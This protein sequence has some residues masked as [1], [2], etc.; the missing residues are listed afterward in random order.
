MEIYQSQYSRINVVCMII[1]NG[2]MGYI[3][4][5]TLEEDPVNLHTQA[6]IFCGVILNGLIGNVLFLKPLYLMFYILRE[7]F[8]HGRGFKLRPIL[9]FLF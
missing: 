8:S 6:I 7:E 1:I 5:E 4:S 3:C 9:C 2:I